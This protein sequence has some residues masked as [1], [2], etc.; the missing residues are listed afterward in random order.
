M[1][2]LF[3]LVLAV[4]LISVLAVPVSAANSSGWYEVLEHSSIQSNGENWF[5]VGQSGKL[6][7]PLN[8][9]KR[10]RK[11]D[12]LIWNPSGQRF[13]SASCTWVGKTTTLDIYAV[14][15]NL[16]RIVGYLPD[17]FYETITIDLK[18][19]TTSSQTYEVLSCKVT[20]IGLQEFAASADVTVD[21]TVYPTD[22]LITV[23]GESGV[24]SPA[25]S[26]IL[27]TVYDWQ[28]YDSLTIWGSA[29]DLPITSIRASIYTAG[30]PFTVSYMDIESAGAWYEHDEYES[31]YTDGD[32]YSGEDWVNGSATIIPEGKY[33][34]CITL[35]LSNV[36]RTLSTY[37]LLVWF[38]GLY[39]PIWGYTFNCQYVNGQVVTA[40]TSGLTWWN[41]FTSFMNGLFGSNDSNGVLDDLGDSSDSISQGAA[42]IYAFEQSQQAVLDNNFT[43]I[44]GAITF[45]NFAAALVFVQKYT[46]MTFNGIRPYAIVL[47]LPLFLGLFFYLCSRIPGITRWKTPPPKSKGGHKP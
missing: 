10:L 18:K 31:G 25:T 22:H 15:S 11:I 5:T 32:I 7:I 3:S 42:D 28:K 8:T 36:E 34:F 47:T 13:T 14:G 43:Q 17:A 26:S 38:T 45:T 33:L 37:H 4:A 40:D 35:D 24:E 9:E 23:A 1:K 46:N 20:P 44:Q 29:T 41:R 16:T 12:L 27:V 39:E 30:I 6:V 21:G 2:K 19:S